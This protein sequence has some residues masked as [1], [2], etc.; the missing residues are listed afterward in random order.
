MRGRFVRGTWRWDASVYAPPHFRRSCSYDAF[1]P[2]PL[3]LGLGDYELSSGLAATLSEVEQRVLALNQTADPAL[4]SLSRLLLRTESIASSKV[5]GMQADA[6]ALAMAEAKVRLKRSVG[7][8]AREIIANIEAMEHAV[9]RTA[10]SE[11]FDVDHLCQVHA[12]LMNRF[13]ASRLAGQLRDSQNWIGGNNYNPCRAAYVPPPPDEVVRLLQNLCDFTES[14]LVSPLVQ[15]AIAHA[16]FETIHPF[17]D[18][19]GRTGRA[20]VQVILRRRRLAPRFVP[21]I[22][23]VLSQ[24]RDMYIQ[25]LIDYREGRLTEWITTFAAATAQAA[26]LALQYS[27]IIHDLLRYWRTRLKL[28]SNPRSDAAAWEILRQL[29]AFPAITVPDAVHATGRSQPAV[30]AA[31]AQLE[32]AG[33][34]I[35]LGQSR[36]NRAWEP[37]GL[38]DLIIAL[39][40]GEVA[41]SRLG[42][43]TNDSQE[44]DT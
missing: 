6:R 40:S 21:P 25:G 38:L 9:Q 17:D 23:V 14:D 10:E 3:D 26:D 33:I 4:V 43:P 19:N 18:G 42:A 1:V 31:F 8:Q 24:R 29:P 41:T 32:D 27:S 44:T 5:E 11:Q 35:P 7:Q 34:L 39:E 22:S 12:A 37:Q 13:P 15:A 36:R 20:L 2:D 28:A 30:N 16:Q